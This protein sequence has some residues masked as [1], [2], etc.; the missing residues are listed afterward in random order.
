MTRRFLDDIRAD[1]ASQMPDNTLGL[2][3]PAIVRNLLN[4]IIDSTIQ[5]ECGIV[6]SVPVAGFAVTTTFTPITTAVFTQDIG[7]DGSF[8]TVN[9]AGGNITLSSTAG[10]AYSVV[11]AISFEAPNNDEIEIVV[12]VDGVPKPY[13]PLGTGR[14]NNRPV[15]VYVDAIINPAPA[16]ALVQVGL[17]A[18][19]GATTILIEDCVLG[20]TIQPTNN[21]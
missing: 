15:T 20:V 7:G 2:I 4:D 17:R 19:A 13:S 5:D 8:L 1:I 3:T 18:P 12:L 10:F 9:A 11:A 6:T 21:P 14:G 16:S